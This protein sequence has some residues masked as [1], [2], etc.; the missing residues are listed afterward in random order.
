MD[1]QI[2]FSTAD[3]FNVCKQ[4]CKVV[5]NDCDDSFKQF[6]LGIAVGA[7]ALICQLSIRSFIKFAKKIYG[8][9]HRQPVGT[10]A[11][12]AHAA[13]SAN[14]AATLSWCTDV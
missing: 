13:P 5:D 9:A 1:N 11:T 4:Q 3:L 8:E 2:C 14:F 6:V 12:S 10:K 7:A